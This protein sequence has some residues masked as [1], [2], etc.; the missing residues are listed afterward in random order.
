[1]E[2]VMKGNET[3]DA[4]NNNGNAGRLDNASGKTELNEVVLKQ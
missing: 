3:F 4:S 2:E 1:M